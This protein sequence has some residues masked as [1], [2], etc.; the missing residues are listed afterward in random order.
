MYSKDVHPSC[1][2]LTGIALTRSLVLSLR[3]LHST[4]GDISVQEAH[5]LLRHP[6][7]HT[8]CISGHA[9]LDRVLDEAG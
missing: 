7:V 1:H 6:G 8:L 2:Y 3:E 5:G 9:Q 4:D